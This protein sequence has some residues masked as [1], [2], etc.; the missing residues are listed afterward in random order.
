[1]YYRFALGFVY[2]MSR[3]A[4][5]KVICNNNKTWNRRFLGGILCAVI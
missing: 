2:F 3:K 1:V 4:Q 5:F